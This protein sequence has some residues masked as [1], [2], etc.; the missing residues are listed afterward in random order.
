MT[1]MMT[2]GLHAIER[3]GVLSPLYLS[4]SETDVLFR[5][6]AEL[7]FHKRF[8]EVGMLYGVSTS[9]FNGHFLL[10]IPDNLP[11]YYGQ[12]NRNKVAY[13]IPLG[14]FGFSMEFFGENFTKNIVYIDDESMEDG[15]YYT[16][17]NG[18]Y[19]LLATW[20]KQ[21]RFFTAGLNFKYY[22]YRDID[23]SE[24]LRRGFG[25]DLGF[26]FT[27]LEELYMGFV[28]NDVGG[29]YYKDANWNGV[30]NNGVAL[31]TNQRL[32]L[33]AAV[34]SGEDMS[35]NLGIP[36][37]E[38]RDLADNPRY[39]WRNISVYGRKV[40]METL[41]CGFGYNTKD[42]YAQ[43]GFNINDYIDLGIIGYKDVFSDGSMRFNA[44]LKLGLAFAQKDEYSS[45]KRLLKDSPQYQKEPKRN[46]RRLEKKRFPPKRP[47]RSRSK[48]GGS[49]RYAD[50]QEYDHIEGKLDDK[51]ED[52]EEKR[53]KLR[54]MRRMDEIRE[55]ID[56][57]GD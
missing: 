37:T 3:T 13:H 48:R 22:H 19:K 41:E 26:Y 10:H 25:T 8:L 6:P 30:I 23:D 9:V 53:R 4:S 35:V 55:A 28:V 18:G 56:V 17:S 57:E 54:H 2:L 14:H 33:S 31:K 39:F 29:T 11:V 21:T 20:A 27:P 50:E 45:I 32:R 46:N 47:E 44:Y 51:I 16:L 38:L 36:L 42:V 15:G 43:I 49:G 12:N 52:L 1:L 24:S 5:N 7:S 34:L 40:F